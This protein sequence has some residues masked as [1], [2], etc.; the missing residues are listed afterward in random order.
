M[1]ATSLSDN[2]KYPAFCY[3]AARHD[4]IFAN[5]KRNPIYN[6]ILEHLTPEQGAQYLDVILN[7]YNVEFT[8]EQW[9]IILQN[10]IVG[11]PRTATYEF[12]D[13]I[14]T[15]APTTLRYVKVL[16]D[17]V[18]LFDFDKIQ[19][20][21]EIGIGYGGQCRLAMNLLPIARYDLIDLPEVILLA[22]RFLTEL[23]QS[24]NIRYI[25]GT[26]L[27]NDVPC[28]LVISNYAFAELAKSVQDFYIDKIVKHSNAGYMTWNSAVFAMHG[29][30]VGYS[31]EEF[32]SMIPGARL[33][34]EVPLTAPGNCIIVWGTK[35][36]VRCSA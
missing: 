11:N 24:G 15:C 35:Q 28:D 25:D 27:Y 18:S 31:A 23:D 9:K 8:D 7:D 2:K 4:E 3:N 30:H 5:F 12:G 21:A 16:L 17:L 34:P 33:I 1:T 32:A 6:Q 36:K 10:D 29:V 22:E 13:K 26:H 14:L 20:V 19:T